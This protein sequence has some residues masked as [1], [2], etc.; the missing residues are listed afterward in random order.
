MSEDDK[1][2]DRALQR[3]VRERQNKTGESYQAAW[4]QMTDDEAP[5]GASHLR[6][7]TPHRISRILLPLSSEGPILPGRSVSVPITARSQ[8]ATFWPDRL[9]IKN[10]ASWSIQQL[11][12]ENKTGDKHSLIETANQDGA[13]FSYATW[14]PLP[15]REVLCGDAVVLAATYCGSSAKG[16]RFEATL[17]GWEDG[18]PAKATSRSSS[19]GS[20]HNAGRISER[21][22]SPEA[23]PAQTIRL[24]WTITTPAL[25]VDRVTIA[26][27]EDWVIND[28]RVRGTSIFVQSGD[29]PA[30]MFSEAADDVIDAEIVSEQKFLS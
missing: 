29:V 11:T 16:E 18:L 3:R 12:V 30:A 25:F 14:Q 17:F 5:D 4:R 26:N 27:A 6:E 24:P 1:K 20:T 15:A 2:R 28:I 9:L 23:R 7:T 22:T 8:I 13:A 21:A 19:T 10:A